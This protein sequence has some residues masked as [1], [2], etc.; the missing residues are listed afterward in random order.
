MGRQIFDPVEKVFDDRKRR[1]TDLRECSRVT[2]PRPLKPQ[3]EANI[4]IRR[5]AQAKIFSD[6]RDK[7]VSDRG[8][9]ESNLTIEEKDGLKTLMKKISDRSVVVVKTDKSSRFVVTT[10]DEYIK[11]GEAHTSKDRKISRWEVC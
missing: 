8:E 5:G 10:E 7:Y 6:Y 9:Q 2:L 1:V 3:E 4:E 11:M